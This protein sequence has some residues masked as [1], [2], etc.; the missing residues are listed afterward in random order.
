[1]ENYVRAVLEMNDIHLP[2]QDYPVLTERMAGLAQLRAAV[3]QEQLNN[4]NMQLLLIPSGGN[5]K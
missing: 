5:G 1:L 3:E 2:D 4:F